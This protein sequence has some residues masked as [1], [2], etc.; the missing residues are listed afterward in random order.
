[1][2]KT[3]SLHR[4]TARATTPW[5]WRT[6]FGWLPPIKWSTP[7]RCMLLPSRAVSSTQPL[8]LQVMSGWQSLRWLPLLT[9]VILMA[10]VV[11]AWCSHGNTVAR[12]R[13]TMMWRK[14]LRLGCSSPP[15][16]ED[17]KASWVRITRVIR[18]LWALSMVMWSVLMSWVPSLRV[19]VLI[20]IVRHQVV[21]SWRSQMMNRA[22]PHS[23]RVSSH[24]HLAHFA[25]LF[26]VWAMSIRSVAIRITLPW[27]VASNCPTTMA[28]IRSQVLQMAVRWAL[29]LLGAMWLLMPLLVSPSQRLTV[30]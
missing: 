15:M 20:S 9:Q 18:S 5:S 19:Q 2:V 14:L 25:T 17:R 3:I 8:F 23:W 24:L 26:L 27:L 12:I 28:S 22:S 21:I 16:Q 29:L 4:L 10:M 7:S 13:L 11:C 1:M 6:I 30:M